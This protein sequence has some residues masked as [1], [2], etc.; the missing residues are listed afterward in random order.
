[1]PENQSWLKPLGMKLEKI[2]QHFIFWLPEF[3]SSRLRNSPRSSEAKHLFWRTV[4]QEFFIPSLLLIHFLHSFPWAR[5]A[6]LKLLKLPEPFFPAMEFDYCA[7]RQINY[8]SSVFL[9]STLLLAQQTVIDQHKVRGGVLSPCRS[10]CLLA[11]C[12]LRR[13]PSSQK[14]FEHLPYFHVN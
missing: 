5:C 1:M 11:A 12:L 4:F 8:T 10:A 3:L 13:S 7:S 6:F 2:K 9:I 14:L